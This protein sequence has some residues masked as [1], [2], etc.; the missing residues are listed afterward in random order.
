MKTLLSGR[1]DL[2]LDRDA[3]SRFLPWLIAFMVFLAVLALTGMLILKEVARK[4][5]TGVSGTLSVQI[6]PSSNATNDE[7]RLSEVLKV[8]ASDR[9]I[10]R[11]EVITDERMKG[12]LKPW[13]G[14]IDDLSELPLP[15]LID[16]EVKP[17]Q[18]L[19]IGALADRLAVVVPGAS[20][21]DHQ[22]WLERLINLIRTVQGVATLILIFIAFATIGTV[23]FTTRTGLAIHREAIEVLHL[24]GAQDNYIAR[25]FSRRALMLGLK[26]GMIGLMLGVPTIW[27]IGYL[28]KRM[29]GFLLPDMQLQAAHWIGV[30]VLPLLV[31][32]IAMMTARL[33]VMR[34][35][36]RML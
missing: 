33:T 34:T 25:Q 4:W 36:S 31:A 15:Q 2:P 17:G 21:D 7:L 32:I 9:Q 6:A 23:I 11:Y 20:V 19:D 5:D 26:G 12:L 22:V 8:L 35:L 30:G 13:L 16:V 28:A 27:G 14:K 24:I 29:D 3:H 10:A 1:S 18:R